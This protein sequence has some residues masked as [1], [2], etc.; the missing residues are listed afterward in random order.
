LKQYKMSERKDTY[1]IKTPLIRSHE[2]SLIYSE[3]D[4]KKRNILLKLEN[5]QPSGSYKLRGISNLVLKVFA[6]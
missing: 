5:C 4:E 6:V 2:L 3:G 1:Y